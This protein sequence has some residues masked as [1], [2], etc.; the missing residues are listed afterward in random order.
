MKIECCPN[1]D[2]L[3]LPSITFLDPR[4][5]Y[6]TCKGCDFQVGVFTDS[7]KAILFWNFLREVKY[8]TI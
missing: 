7:N 2:T 1:C 5:W 6:I 3:V 4:G 8:K